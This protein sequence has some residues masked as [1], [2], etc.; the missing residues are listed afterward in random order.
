[1]NILRTITLFSLLFSLTITF[2]ACFCDI[3]DN[4]DETQGD[5]DEF[6]DDDTADDDTD[7]YDDIA[8]DDDEEWP[9]DVTITHDFPPVA[10]PGEYYEYEFEATGGKKPYHDWTV[11]HGALP[12]GLTLNPDT[13]LLSGTTAEEEKLYY[14]VVAVTD[15]SAEPATASEAFGLRVGDPDEDG[16]LLR[17]ARAYQAIYDERHNCDGLSVTADNPD[18]P[19]GDYWFT[20]LGDACFIHGNSSAGAAFWYAVEGTDEAL[21]NARLHTRGLDLLNR[22]NGIPGL[23]SRSYIPKDAPMGPNEF[24]SFTPE[25][26]NHVGEGE[27][28]DYYW[29]GDVSIDQYSGALVGLSLMYDLVDDWQI[30]YT[31]RRNIIEIADYMWEGGLRIYDVDGEPTTYGDF[32]GYFLEGWPVPNGLAA[33]ASLAWFRLAYH[34]SGEQRFLDHYNELIERDYPW[35]VSGFLWVYLGYATKHY[36]VY[37]A[38]ENMYTLTRL[39]KNLILW[40]IYSKAFA[41]QLWDD[42][43]EILALRRGSS[44]ANPTFS[45]WFQ[46]ST[47]YR[48]PV[49]IMQSIWQMDAFVDPP[50]R[51]RYI[52]NSANPDI[53]KNPQRPELALEPLPADLRVPDMCIWHRSPFVLDGGDD[54]GRERTGHDYLLPY[55]MGRYYGYIGPEW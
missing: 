55:W 47:A 30:Q 34:V 46:Y 12:T 22:V 31:V 36:N 20:D 29:K 14:F 11:T 6:L 27:F 2:S 39:E 40:D 26:E 52:E 51:D 5:D 8:D 48:D 28:A 24:T 37:M 3:D 35:V 33:A 50:L 32:R 19:D 43:G 15:S 18:A 54:N 1:M 13:G 53:E 17:K 45:P 49:T 42:T 41:R 21:D 9:W 25:S 38:Y 23:L 16:P 10:E 7:N 44:E 4:D